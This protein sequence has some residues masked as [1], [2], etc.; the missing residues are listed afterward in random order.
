M[1]IYL[2]WN[3][4]DRLEKLDKLEQEEKEVY[5][6]IMEYISINNVNIPYS[7]AHL[8]DLL[9][10]FRKNPNFIEGHL[11]IIE[12]ITQNLC[13]CQ[14]WGKKQAIWH[15]RSVRDFF[16]EI[17][18]EKSHEVERF[19]ELGS[20]MGRIN[21]LQNELLRLQ[22]VPKEFKKIYSE[23]PIF[24]IIYPRTK[25]EMNLLALSADIYNFS[26]LITKDYY[27]YK[28]LRRFLLTSIRKLKKH[29]KVIK[30]IQ[31]QNLE[32]PNYLN[33][34]EVLDHFQK[35]Q[36][37]STKNETFNKLFDT[38]FRF[39]IKGYKADS[40]FNNMVD[41]GLHTFYAAHCDIFITNDERCKFKAIST[42]NKMNIQ[43]QVFNSYEFVINC[44]P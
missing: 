4:L 17:Q 14:Y 5:S 27:L 8:R 34:D 10:G 2:D 24:N 43:T 38:F 26:I 32:I 3:V 36:K 1:L 31:S 15:Y 16:D 19:E 42:Y 29:Q 11:S 39:D 35:N 44:I 21:D 33:I 23:D 28:S 6:K 20:F 30:V 12:E 9:R 41:D 40:H 22:P 18:K 25:N 7:N 13:L 37:Q